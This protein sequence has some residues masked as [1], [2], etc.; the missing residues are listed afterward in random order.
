MVLKDKTVTTLQERP[1]NDDRP[2]M[3]GHSIWR[4]CCR[5]PAAH[6]HWVCFRG[7]CTGPPAFPGPGDRGVASI[8]WG[9]TPEDLPV[10]SAPTKCTAAGRGRSLSAR[11]ECG[12]E[13]YLTL[14]SLGM[15]ASPSLFVRLFLRASSCRGCPTKLALGDQILLHTAQFQTTIVYTASRER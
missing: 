14:L 8:A 1:C 9:V 15:Y 13:I 5:C 11:G 12:C 7:C 10:L 2:S 4:V 3:Q 6:T